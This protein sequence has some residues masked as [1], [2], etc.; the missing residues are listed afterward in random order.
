MSVVQ[1]AHFLR[2]QWLPNAGKQGEDT[3]LKF[4]FDKV[5]TGT[6][7]INTQ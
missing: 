3:I 4:L 6:F 7:F 1:S 5:K 2:V